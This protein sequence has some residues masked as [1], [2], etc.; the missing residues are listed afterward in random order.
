MRMPPAISNAPGRFRCGTADA[1]LRHG[2]DRR[3][4]VRSKTLV[5]RGDKVSFASAGRKGIHGQVRGNAIEGC[6]NRA[7]TSP[8]G[9]L[10]LKG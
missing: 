6:S 2:A 4:G 3:Q 5:L 8:S 1:R 9:A 10:A 7:A